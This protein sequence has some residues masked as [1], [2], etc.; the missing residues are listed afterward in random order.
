M[1]FSIEYNYTHRVQLFF[2]AEPA[3]LVAR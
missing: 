2:H 3:A 1:M